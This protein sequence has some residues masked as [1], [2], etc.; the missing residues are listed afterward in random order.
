MDDE[1]P[2]GE[3]LCETVRLLLASD[4]NSRGTVTALS[5]EHDELTA[6]NE[7]SYILY[8]KHLL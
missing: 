5:Q 4:N 8:L 2:E 3:T 1:S 7:H 6:D